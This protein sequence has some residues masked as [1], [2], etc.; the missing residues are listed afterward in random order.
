MAVKIVTA[1][2]WLVLPATI[3]VV[4]NCCD[5]MSQ[6]STICTRKKTIIEHLLT[7]AIGHHRLILNRI[8]IVKVDTLL[9]CYKF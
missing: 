9:N 5:R 6:L 1:G 3:M 2:I 8:Y 4:A 7:E